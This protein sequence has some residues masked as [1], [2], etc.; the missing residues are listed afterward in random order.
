N[1]PF[2]AHVE[3]VQNHVGISRLDRWL[4]VRRSL[5]PSVWVRGDSTAA[6]AVELRCI[7]ARRVR[8]RADGAVS[9][10]RCELIEIVDADH[11]LE[12]CYAVDH[13][14]EAVLAKTLALVLLE[15]L[16]D[17]VKLVGRDKCAQ[18]GE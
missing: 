3:R 4:D 9:T 10:R 17:G 7:E 5:L 14:L 2:L 6:G 1:G 16:G 15:L 11:A 13:L 8:E 12:P 18:P